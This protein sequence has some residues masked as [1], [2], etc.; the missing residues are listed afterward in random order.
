[1][2]NTKRWTCRA[3]TMAA[4]LALV[5]CESAPEKRAEV[6]TSPTTQFTP[7]PR[8]W[9]ESIGRAGGPVDPTSSATLLSRQRLESAASDAGRAA[10]GL[11]QKNV[12]GESKRL[13]YTARE[14]ALEDVIRVLI[15]EFLGKDYLIDPKLVEGKK[16]P[17]TLDVDA[18]VTPQ[19]VEDILGALSTLYGW[20]LERRGDLI[21]VGAAPGMARSPI[22]PLLD[23]AALNASDQPAAR[24]FRLRHITPKDLADTLKE[25]MSEGAKAAVG[26]RTL[27]VVDR[28]NQLNRIGA[29][30]AAIDTPAFD[31]AELW[32]YALAHEK[33]AEAAKI[34][35]S[36]AQASGLAAA[37]D[38]T[39]SFL[40][41]PRGNRLVVISR[42]GSVQPMVRGWVETVDAPPGAMTRQRYLYRVQHWD[43]AKLLTFLR[44]AFSDRMER[45]AGGNDARAVEG[46]ETGIRL[47]MDAEEEVMLVTATPRDYAELLSVIQRVDVARQQV[48]IQTVIAEV[49]LTNGLQF[50]VEYFLQNEID[51]SQLDLIGNLTT[52]GPTSALA[53]GSAFFLASDGFA[54]VKALQSESDTEIVV[55]P[56]AIVRDK[57]K[58]NVQVGG[59]VPI[60]QSVIETQG[61][62]GGNTDLRNQIEYK[63]TGVILDIQPRINETGDVTLVLSQEVRDVVA[64]TTEGISSPSF[65][66]RRVET[67]VI[68]P[69]GKTLLLGGI[70]TGN[71]TKMRNRIPLLSDIPFAGLAFTNIN[72]RETSTELVLTITPTI[73]SDP[74]EGAALASEFIRG[75]RDLDEALRRFDGALPAGIGGRTEIVQESEPIRENEPREAPAPPPPA[76]RSAQPAALVSQA[77]APIED[78]D[79]MVT[80]FLVQLAGLAGAPPIGQ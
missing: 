18:D 39:V 68:V 36:L 74:A 22:M 30:I 20:T 6:Q 14:A 59:E 75:T 62:T 43:P 71:T 17:I 19:D 28:V 72:D 2:M 11:I 76:P 29:I 69:H 23:G 55:S 42:D 70:K 3:L 10:P 1:M 24:V 7:G 49:S 64:T 79:G 65:T 34:L 60:L 78:P 12:V 15:G 5:A 4:G 45:E 63:Q 67:T 26:G 53:A 50:G 25:L 47:T 61:Q 52:L 48:H 27:V 32:T 8:K 51:G 46:G 35:N 33:A 80:E 54:L 13:K 37:N 21:V 16:T 9:Q 44:A 40:A 66:T 77:C 38:A 57:D 58:A 31:G 41:L 56:S 73:I